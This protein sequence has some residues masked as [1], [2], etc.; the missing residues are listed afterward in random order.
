MFI[1]VISLYL[2]LSLS[3]SLSPLPLHFSLA[4][5]PFPPLPPFSPLSLSYYSL[6]MWQLTQLLCI[7][8]L[9][10]WIFRIPVMFTKLCVYVTSNQCV[11]YY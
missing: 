10:S 3:P 1:V 8:G 9:I 2:S 5:P 7:M 6:F 11:L 4:L